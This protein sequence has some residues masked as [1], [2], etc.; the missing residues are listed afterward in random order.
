MDSF[1]VSP[2]NPLTGCGFIIFA[3][4]KRLKRSIPDHGIRNDEKLIMVG[5]CDA[6]ARFERL[7]PL[8]KK[9]PTGL[10]AG[11]NPEC[12]LLSDS[13]PTYL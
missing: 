3:T 7:L 11:N 6:G 10:R 12:T 2:S 4:G 13:L 5:D 9:G 1:L 8:Q